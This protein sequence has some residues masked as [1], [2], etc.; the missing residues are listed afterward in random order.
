M[1]GKIAYNDY[2][3][4]VISTAVVTG[5]ETTTY[6][7]EFAV[8]NSPASKW[9][10]TALT[11]NILFD[12][13]SAVNIKAVFAGGTNIISGDTTWKIRAGTTSDTED[14]NAGLTKAIKSYL[15]IDQTY[16]YWKFDFVGI[17]GSYREFGKLALF[18]GLYEFPWNYRWEYQAGNEEGNNVINGYNGSIK[19][20]HKYQRAIRTLN[21]ERMGKAQYQFF[22]ETLRPLEE[23]VYYDDRESEAF[24]GVPIF[25]RGATASRAHRYSMVLNFTEAL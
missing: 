6:E 14:Y 25:R 13:G 12:L 18:G 15:E 20:I 7:K 3:A 16:R 9:R 21:F 1:G 2:A 8:D 17:G 10:T 5:G 24:Y 4:G 11:G 19:K 23:C 22:N